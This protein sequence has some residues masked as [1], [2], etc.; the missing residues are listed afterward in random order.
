MANYTKKAL[1]NAGKVFAIS[2][3][4]GFFG[5]IVRIF[6]ARNLTVEEFGLF[7]ATIAF[8]GFF[9][10]FKGLGLDT[11]LAFFIPKIGRAHV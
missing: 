8:L 3:V 11:A 5:Y 6:F 2:I 1:V 7:Y 4:A 9:S 10:F